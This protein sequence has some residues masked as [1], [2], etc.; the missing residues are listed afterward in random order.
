MYNYIFWVVHYN[1]HF[2][3]SDK[4]ISKFKATLALCFSIVVHVGLLI[5][6]WKH[7]IDWSI[8]SRF[9]TGSLF[10]GTILTVMACLVF[11]YYS[12]ARIEALD[13]RF[14]NRRWHQL[15]DLIVVIL[16][17]LVPL[18]GLILLSIKRH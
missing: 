9:P 18:V 10:L 2:K 1:S 15:F 13:K 16:L 7:F 3:E 4:W 8:T 12:D 17:I 6:I 14:S 11:W 5:A